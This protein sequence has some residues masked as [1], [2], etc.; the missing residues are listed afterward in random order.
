MITYRCSNIVRLH[1]ES[2]AVLS[3]F[4]LHRKTVIWS[5]S[6]DRHIGMLENVL[7][8]TPER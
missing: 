2:L 6:R 3:L 4:T 7:S 1:E 5:V 8:V